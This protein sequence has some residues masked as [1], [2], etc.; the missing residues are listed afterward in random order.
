M[1]TLNYV[2]K[3]NGFL[4]I[5]EGHS[6]ANWI[7][8]S[9]ETKSTSGYVFTLGGSVVNWRSAKQTIIG[10]S[11]MESLFGALELAG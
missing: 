5:L 8:N 11:T 6:D 3:H 7:P 10:R 1:S 2:I 4:T 9:Y